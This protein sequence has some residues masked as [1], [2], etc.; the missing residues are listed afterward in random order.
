MHA[1]AHATERAG[2]APS[3]SLQAN[4][5]ALSRAVPH[6]AGCACSRGAG[7]TAPHAP[8]RP[9]HVPSHFTSGHVPS[10]FTG[11]PRVVHTDQRPQLGAREVARLRECRARAWHT[12]AGARLALWPARASHTVAS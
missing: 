3:R 9:R 5:R 4:P 1:H 7:R 6:G 8:H 11:G 10:H 12:V 2:R